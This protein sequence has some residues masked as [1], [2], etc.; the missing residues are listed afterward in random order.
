MKSQRKRSFK[1][2]REVHSV[3]KVREKEEIF[4]FFFFFLATYEQLVLYIRTNCSHVAKINRN[5]HPVVDEV[6]LVGL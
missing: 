3:I 1:R 4:E 2:K 6:W 5:P